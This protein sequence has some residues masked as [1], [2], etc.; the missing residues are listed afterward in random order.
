MKIRIATRFDIPQLVEMLKRYRDHSPL[1]CLKSVNDEAYIEELL[2]Q[3]ITGRGTIFV[4][5]YE[6]ELAGMLIAVR[7][8]NAWDPKILALN[9]L[10]YWVDPQ[11]RNTSA[12]YKLLS[13]YRD[14]AQ[15]L[16]DQGQIEYFTISKMVN[17]P[18]LN[19][20]RFGFRKL[21]EMWEQ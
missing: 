11:Y 14:Y 15:E 12:G 7:N 10:A 21:E 17:S 6:K 20:D 19:Y 4:A 8:S 16:K 3:V 13:K 9:E 2:T 18:D 1:A 5:D